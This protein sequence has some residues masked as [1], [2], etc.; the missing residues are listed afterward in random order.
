MNTRQ[1]LV[2]LGLVI[3]GPVSAGDPSVEGTLGKLIEVYGGEKNL[4]KLDTMVQE[5]DML[6]LKSNRPA[7][8][9]RSIDFGGR[10]KVELTY[11]D[12]HETR[13]L[14]GAATHAAL[15][16]AVAARQGRCA[17]RVVQ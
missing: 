17:R 7:D 13:I 15:H 14:N 4:R 11:P 16:A 5:W 6:A 9:R 8:D 12:K 10:L 2:L 1:M 3:A